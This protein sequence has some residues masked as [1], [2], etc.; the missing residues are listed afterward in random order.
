MLLLRFVVFCFLAA[1]PALHVAA[2]QKPKLPKPRRLDSGVV[3]RRDPATGEL[4]RATPPVADAGA[5]PATIRTRVALVEVG[6]NVFASDGAPVRGLT[7]AD[8]RL[9]E[10]GVEQR[11]VHFD[12]STAAASIV[13][14]LDT[15]PSVFRDLDEIRDAARA[16]S[17]SLAPQDEV[18]VVTFAARTRLVLPFTRDR[19]L[20]ERTIA[21]YGLPSD[22]EE[23]RGS[24]IYESVYLAAEDMF[25]GV[26]RTG[27]KAL[28]LLTD[29]QDTGLGLSWDPA[30]AQ[31][32]PGAFADRLAF[33]DVARA[34]AARGIELYAITTQP[35]PVAFTEAWL[36]AH[37]SEMLVSS[38]SRE[39][40]MPHYTLYLAE[41][42]R[43]AG[44]QLFFLR[45][46]GALGDVYRRIAESLGAQYILGFYP[47]AGLAR[48]GWRSLRVELL[49]GARSGERIT[50][51]VAYYVSASP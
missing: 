43:R 41:L 10:D 47:S 19:P 33:E 9:Y 3:L 25:G 30:S 27:R 49:S 4:R 48:P 7:A 34:L 21:A 29:G 22:P 24:R 5:A 36:A 12:A 26:P 50:H 17:R 20:L 38:K 11:I 51:R 23:A 1:L 14:V 32:K 15:S 44:G 13:L 8:F 45:E 46:I 16:L 18:A 42:V 2:Q 28:V 39:A 6:C 31:P 40:G 37:R 35:R